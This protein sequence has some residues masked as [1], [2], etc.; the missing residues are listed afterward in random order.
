MRESVALREFEWRNY[1]WFKL[2]FAVCI[3]Y[4]ILDVIVL[5]YVKFLMETPL[6]TLSNDFVRPTFTWGVN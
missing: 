1:F 2:I 4:K 6:V 5:T 3:K